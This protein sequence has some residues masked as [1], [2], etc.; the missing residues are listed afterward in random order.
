MTIVVNARFLTRKITGVQRY[1]IEI[2][3]I[4]KQIYGD[5]IKFVAPKK[6]IIY[7]DLA[8]QLEAEFYGNS[9]GLLWEQTD[10]PV[11]LKKNN[12]P[13]L[14]GLTNTAP[15]TYHKNVLTVHD[16]IF[17]KDASWFPNKFSL[18]Y[19]L[20]IPVLLNHALKVITVSEFSKQDIIKTFNTPADKIEVAYNAV[21]KEFREYSELDYENKYGN[22]ILAVISFLNPRKNL[23][24]I[25]KA[26]N[27]AGLKDTKLVIAGV[28]ADEFPDKSII[29]KNIVFAGY[30]KDKG[31]AGLYKNAKLL[32]FPSL[33]EGFG[34]PPL[35]AMSCGCPVIASNLTS[36]PEVC[37]D[38]AYYVNPYDV[39]DIASAIKHVLNNENLQNTLRK[40]GLERANFFSWKSSANKIKEILENL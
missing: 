15:I 24:N 21:S 9:T 7:H 27:K 2:S 6:D 10:L 4:L 33:F 18:I 20:G 28:R 17:M 16:L 8:K 11:Y 32:V 5:K 30:M 26:Y 36:L 38:A 35:E 19:K 39:E 14:L 13:V 29:N 1:A 34:I 23:G 31:L 3:L 40:K 12:N 22:Y 37:G 25:I